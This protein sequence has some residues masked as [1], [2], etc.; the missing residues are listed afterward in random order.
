V[1]I[2]TPEECENL[3]GTK[4][5]GYG[6]T[7][8]ITVFEFDKGNWMS[9]WLDVLTTSYPHDERYILE[10]FDLL[11]YP[12]LDYLLDRLNIY[13]LKS[14]HHNHYNGEG[15]VRVDK[16]KPL[17]YIILFGRAT[18]IPRY[19]THYIVAHEMGHVV[20][21]WYGLNST[22]E[23]QKLRGVKGNLGFSIQDWNGWK[24]LWAEDWR[25]LFS[26]DSAHQNTWAAE[27]PPPGEEIR[28]FML[29]L[30]Q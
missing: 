7:H 8:E 24:Q 30:V 4:T 29:G 26:R 5:E 25:W 27:I 15:G 19:M 10:T 14:P 12:K 13:R 18:P 21:E 3:Y 11:D 22:N 17:G 2:W 28:E 16:N 6:S 9:P 1:R 20:Q 23:Y